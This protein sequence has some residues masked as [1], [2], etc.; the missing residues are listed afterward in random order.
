MFLSCDTETEKSE[1]ISKF[2]YTQ[3]TIPIF[4]D[5]CALSPIMH[6]T[7]HITTMKLLRTALLALLASLASGATPIKSV[8]MDAVKADSDLGL[9]LLS[10]ARRVEEE[11]EG[12]EE[13]GDNNN[14]NNNGVD[15]T[16][17]AGYSLKFQGC[18]HI[19]QWNADA[20]ENEDVRIETKRL[21]RFRLCPTSSCN[22]RNAAGCKSGYGDYIVDMETF[23][24]AYYEA[25]MNIQSSQCEEYA[26]YN[27]NCNNNNGGDEEERK[28][29]EGE[30]GEEG[31]GENG[32]D[33][34]GNDCEYQCFYDAE[35]FECLDGGD[36]DFDPQD[37]MACRGVGQERRR[38]LE[39]GE[40]EE[41]NEEGNE[42]EGGEDGDQYGY[43]V[44]PY[45][46]T[47]GGEIRLGLFSDDSCTEEADTTYYKLTGNELPYENESIIG[48]ECL[49]CAEM[50]DGNDDGNGDADYTSEQCETIYKTAGKCE[51]NLPSGTVEQKSTNACGY[52][53]GIKITR[54]DGIV[55]GGKSRS[56]VATTFI[57]LFA[58]L[59]AVMAFYVYYLRK[60]LGV[61]KDSLL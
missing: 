25:K 27:C 30:D 45:C 41:G 43:Y 58:L 39:E 11:G 23:L 37:Y 52:M 10:Q 20:D 28:L 4:G 7:Q 6:Q 51:N 2:M 38:K 14:N 5:S 17:V 42:E 3:W 61:K 1:Y 35:M 29:E 47:Q 31:E 44:G 18:H 60:R 46:A 48:S 15:V 53:E 19:K 24:E 40:G 12:G 16:W 34:G 54:E 56:K 8:S 26:T 13:N 55:Y 36:G 49:S 50:A 59:F 33:N 57:V 21:V 22:A 32:N 9:N